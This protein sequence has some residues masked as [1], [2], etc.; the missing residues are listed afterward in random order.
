MK[1]SIITPNYNYAHFIGQTIESVLNQNYFDFEHIIVDDGSTDNSVEI[2][3]TYQRKYPDKIKLVIQQNM[4]Q[5]PA[6]NTG[7]KVATGDIIGWINS[8]DIY[9]SNTFKVVNKILANSDLDAI[10]SN[11]CIVD[12]DNNLIKKMI[13][14]NSIKWMSL[15][16]CFIP[17]NTFFFKRKI[18]DAGILIDNEFH[19]SMDKE[20]FAHIYYSNFN[21]RKTDY[22]FAFFRLH[23]KNKSV[24]TV[25]AKR[26]RTREGLLVFNKYSKFKL[27]VNIIGA[28]FYDMGTMFCSF[29]R[30]VSKKIGVGVYNNSH[31]RSGK[32][33][34]DF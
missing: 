7:L 20:F 19:L 18:I 29:I 17:S 23:S 33:G 27:P 8:D 34:I 14:Q 22:Y 28:L 15:F 21:I 31:L 3:Q 5:S 12:I 26:I 9:N 25:N 4:G 16:Y 30:F 1:I 11:T 32:N 24:D 13:T 2:I 10:Y 6:I